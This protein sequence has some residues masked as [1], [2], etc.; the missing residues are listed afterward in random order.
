[1]IYN[2]SLNKNVE[3]A[4][5]NL[6]GFEAFK[7]LVEEEPTNVERA[8]EVGPEVESVNTAPWPQSHG[9]I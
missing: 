1:M 8:R 2:K 4:D 3:D 5:S 9:S 6:G 7:T